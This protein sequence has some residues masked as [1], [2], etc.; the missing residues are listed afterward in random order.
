M[1]KGGHI[2]VEVSNTFDKNYPMTTLAWDIGKI[3]A[4]YFYL[5][6]D[7]IFCHKNGKIASSSNNNTHSYCLVY[8]NK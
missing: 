2:V 1:K 7:F 4:K 3:V 6:R 8:K 5:E